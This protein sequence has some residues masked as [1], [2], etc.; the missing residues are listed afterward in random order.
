MESLDE[1]R[2]RI[3]GQVEEWEEMVLRWVYQVAREVAVMVLEEAAVG[4]H[5]FRGYKDTAQDV[6][7]QPGED[8]RGKHLEEALTAETK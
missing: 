8:A 7:G 4:D 6:P 1:T 5:A 2:V 3:K